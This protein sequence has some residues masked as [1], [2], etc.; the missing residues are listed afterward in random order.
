MVT[1]EM[2]TNYMMVK[3]REKFRQKNGET[4]IETLAALLITTLGLMLL[5]GA[6][7]SSA[8]VN[9][10]AEKQF[11]YPAS[12][13]DGASSTGAKISKTDGTVSISTGNQGGTKIADVTITKEEKNGQ[14]FY[15]YQIKD[16]GSETGQQDEQNN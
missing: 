1:D 13:T 9:A 11:I 16:T 5:P 7:V 12:D 4:L 14:I 2:I 15:S 10:K 6:V 8:R 3:I